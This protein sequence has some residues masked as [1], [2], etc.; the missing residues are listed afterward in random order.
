MQRSEC[1]VA[2][3]RLDPL[4][5]ALS[6]VPVKRVRAARRERYVDA[7]FRLPE[8]STLRAELI[9]D[10]KSDPLADAKL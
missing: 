1:A 7:V 4:V 8:G 3:E 9:S 5:M 6:T 2:I 10:A